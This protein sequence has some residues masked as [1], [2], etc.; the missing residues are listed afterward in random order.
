MLKKIL[1]RPVTVTMAVLV[2]VVLGIVSLRSMPV[3]LIPDLDIPY[4]TVQVTDQSL[5]AREMDK[6]VLRPLR[7]QLI[8]VN[9]LKDIVT[10][11]RDGSGTIKLTFDQGSDI[12]Y[13]FIEVNEKIDRSLASL[14]KI[15]RPKVFKASATDIPAFYV[16]MTLRQN[17]GENRFSDMSQ[18]ASEVVVKRIE[19]LPQVAMADISGEV[20]PEILII[21]DEKKLLQLGL[22]ISRFESYVTSANVKLGSLTIRDG[23]YRYSVKF[24]S[25]AASKEDIA[26]IYFKAGGKILQIKDVAKVVEKPAKRNGL[27]RSDGKEAITM[28]VIKQNDARMSDLKKEMKTLMAQFSKDYPEVK[29][30]V[31]RD[32]TALLEYSINNLFGNI[33]L[34]ILLAC[35]VIFL[36]M[37]D[38]RSPALVSLTIP[39]SLLFSMLV[40]YCIGISINIISLSGLVLGVGMLTDNTVVLIDNITARWQRGDDLRTAVLEGTG[41]VSGAMLSSVLTTCAV[42]IPLIFVSGIAGAMFYDQAMSITIVLL[43]SYIVT[44]TVIPVYYWWWYKKSESF[45]PNRFLERFS[46]DKAVNWYDKG[47]TL[48]MRHR[49]IGWGLFALSAVGIVVCFSLM[50]KDKLPEITYS[51]TV[52][53]IDWNES[54]SLGTND[55]RVAALCSAVKKYTKQ[56]TAL[57]GVQQFVLN[58]GNEQSL[59]EASLYMKCHDAAMLRR[60]KKIIDDKLSAEYPL[61]TATFENPGNIFELVFSDQEPPL[62]AKLRPVSR[63]ELEVGLL[64]QVMDKLGRKFKG[65]PDV[66]V[67]TDILYIADPELMTLYG[68]SFGE[69]I[70]VLEN[71]LSG[72]NLFDIVYGSKSLPVVMG[73]DSGNIDEILENRFIHRS[74]HDIPVSALMKR[75]EDEDLKTIFAGTEGNYYPV[76]FDV[77]SS[78]ARKTMKEVD[79]IVRKDGNFEVGFGGSWFS[80]RKMIDDMAVVILIAIALLYLILASQFE[81]LIQPLLILSEVVID[82]FFSLLVLWIC[83]VSINLMSLIGLVVICG[84]VINDSILKIDTI[85]RLR[86]SGM[87]LEHSILEAGQRRMK[88]IIMTSL[89]TIFSVCPFLARGNMGADLQYPMSLVIIAGMI[90]GTLVS[91]FF[92]PMFYFSI[93]R[94]K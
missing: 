31:T 51:D 47:V 65:I 55:A 14:P 89:T 2:I 42:F 12:D 36:F 26:D 45:K 87:G 49:W 61:S 81:S 64:R 15:D 70:K 10:E 60:V 21:P 24:Q 67:K 77:S 32:Q 29:F 39:L 27:V 59:S 19:Q 75:T 85:N 63:P 11:A 33:A 52:L 1:D 74:D 37:K 38:F 30:E 13:I 56:T 35:I 78:K 57:V 50:R 3:S 86:K 43:T 72:N 91:L 18:F 53:K 82:I 17:G 5:S 54:V 28:A 16:N 79:S 71:A 9:A 68:V 34:G 7:Q 83:G 76:T 20:S 4:I 73:T 40:F 66:S 84:I 80:N 94:K 41:E 44:I 22:D 8:Q 69:L 23:E 92:I 46:F 93:Y 58:N 88:A 48:M 6:S 62:V 90:V 25:F